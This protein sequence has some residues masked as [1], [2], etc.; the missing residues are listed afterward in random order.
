MSCK[1]LILAHSEVTFGYSQSFIR[2]L[3]RSGALNF[4]IP[5]VHTLAHAHTH[6]HTHTHT[7]NLLVVITNKHKGN[8]SQECT[9]NVNKCSYEDNK[10]M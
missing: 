6:T 1:F 7:Q 5:N 10:K 2:R 9:I 3:M 4:T 8:C